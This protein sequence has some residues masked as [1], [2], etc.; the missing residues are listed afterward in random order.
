MILHEQLA[1]YSAFLKIHRKLCTYSLQST[2]VDKGNTPCTPPPHPPPPTHT[3]IPEGRN[4]FTSLPLHSRQQILK[5]TRPTQRQNDH[6]KEICDVISFCRRLAH[7]TRPLL[8]LCHNTLTPARTPRLGLCHNT[9]TPAR[10]PRLGLFHN[11][12]TPA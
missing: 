8:G 4:H 5:P 6:L 2:P 3:L 12:L 9:L 11:T 7:F 1:F 10:T